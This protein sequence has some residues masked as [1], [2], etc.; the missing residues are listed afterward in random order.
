MFEKWNTSGNPY[1]ALQFR[2]IDVG[3]PVRFIPRGGVAWGIGQ[4]EGQ[5]EWS[6]WTHV[7]M[8]ADDGVQSLFINGQMVD[9]HEVQEYGCG[10]NVDITMG[11]RPGYGNP[12][13]GAVD[14]F[15]IWDRALTSVEIINIGTLAA[16]LRV[17]CTVAQTANHATTILTRIWTTPPA[18][19]CVNTATMARCGMK[20]F[21]RA[22]QPTPPITTPMDVC[23]K[24]MEEK[25]FE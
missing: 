22:S 3:E 14:D 1:P 6:A 7:A 23:L 15:A 8:V 25:K 17:R 21:T 18:T 4:V 20:R 16:S 12:F 11:R 9:Q 2:T 24:S 13:L 10:N 5:I 19:T